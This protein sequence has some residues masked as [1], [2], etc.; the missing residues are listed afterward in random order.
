MYLSDCYLSII[1]E[2]SISVY[3]TGKGLSKGGF[4]WFKAIIEENQ[5]HSII[6]G[7]FA[8]ISWVKHVLRIVLVLFWIGILWFIIPEIYLGIVMIPLG[9]VITLILKTLFEK[10]DS[11]DNK[12]EIIEFLTNLNKYY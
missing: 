11:L 10:T 9:I 3:Y 8:V 4:K 7:R 1:N 2:D 6:I 12:K 5:E